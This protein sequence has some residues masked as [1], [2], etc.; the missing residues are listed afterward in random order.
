MKT[1]LNVLEEV[2][3]KTYTIACQINQE[4][5]QNSGRENLIYTQ[6]DYKYLYFNEKVLEIISNVMGVVYGRKMSEL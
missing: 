2:N 4:I 3:R 5:T 1:R 6:I